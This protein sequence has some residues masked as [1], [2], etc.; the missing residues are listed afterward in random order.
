[1]RV[2]LADGGELKVIEKIETPKDPTQGVEAIR[3]FLEKHGASADEA[4][5]S[6]AGALIIDGRPAPHSD[7][8]EPGKQIIDYEKMRTP[9]DMCGGASL[10]EEFGR[11]PQALLYDIGCNR[12]NGGD[13]EK[14]T[15]KVVS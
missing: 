6:I 3:A 7:G 9:E 12:D 1:M 2:A 11:S 14:V 8:H 15:G 10:T 5:G 13:G 4:V